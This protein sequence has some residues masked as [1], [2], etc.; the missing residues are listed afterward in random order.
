MQPIKC[1]T[2]KLLKVQWQPQKM[3]GSTIDLKCSSYISVRYPFLKRFVLW[4]NH[5]Q[6]HHSKQHSSAQCTP[7]PYPFWIAIETPAGSQHRRENVAMA[8][9]KYP[10]KRWNGKTVLKIWRQLNFQAT[11]KHL[12]IIINCFEIDQFHSIIENTEQNGLFRFS[13]LNLAC[14]SRIRI[15]FGWTPVNINSCIWVRV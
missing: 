14:T 2:R 5:F 8:E 1:N 7:V 12:A 13:V 11:R 10:S 15:A 4:H 6:H 9:S 3:V